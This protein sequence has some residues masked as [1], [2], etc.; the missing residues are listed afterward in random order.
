MTADAILRTEG[1]AIGKA[2]YVPHMFGYLR[3]GTV[4]V[5]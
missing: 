4:A 3:A 1:V 2:D 5:V